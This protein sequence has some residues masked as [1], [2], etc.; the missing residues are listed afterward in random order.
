MQAGR[1]IAATFKPWK[2]NDACYEISEPP[3]TSAFSLK[4]VVKA[5]VK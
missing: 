4:P 5:Y 1:E 2:I 3:F